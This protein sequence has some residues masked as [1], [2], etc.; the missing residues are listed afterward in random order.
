MGKLKSIL[1]I[2][3]FSGILLIAACSK[4][5]PT[6]PRGTP[7][8]DAVSDEKS[9]TIYKSSTCG[10]CSAYASYMKKKGFNVKVID[11][12]DLTPIKEKYG[13]PYI[14]Q[15]CHTLVIGE[16]FVEGH[17]PVEAINKLLS[18][19]PDIK[20][21]AMPGMPS[22][23]PGMPGSKTSDFVISAVNKDNTYPEFVR[24]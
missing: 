5:E 2:L 24:M 14:L 12:P 6:A 13:I 16:Y 9:V 17:I 19:K 3:F 21:I 7:T 8:G 11:M 22:A 4:K 1:L 18:E 23:S 20:G 10:C 15:S